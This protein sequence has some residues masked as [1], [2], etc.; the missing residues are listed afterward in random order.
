MTTLRALPVLCLLAGSSLVA[1]GNDVLDTTNASSSS[2]AGAGGG[3]S[4]SGSGAGTGGGWEAQFPAPHPGM[5]VIPTHGGATL[6]DPVIVT[7]TFPDDPLTDSAVSFGEQ[8]GGLNW[9]STVLADYG[10][11]PATSGGH[12]AMTDA[13]TATMTDNDLQTW[14]KGKI[15]DGTLP[16]PTDQHIYLLWVPASTTITLPD[17]QGPQSSCDAFLGYHSSTAMTINNVSVPIAYAVVNE[18]PPY[19]GQSALDG[20]T[21]TA[22][23]ELAEASSD[24]H[25]ISFTP[26]YVILGNTP[27][28]FAGGENADMCSEVSGVTEAGFYLT[29]VWSNANAK[30]G[31]QPCIPVPDDPTDTPYFNGGIVNETLKAKPGQTVSTEVD[32]YAFGPLANELTLQAMPFSHDVLTPSFDKATCINGEQ[33]KLSFKVSASAQPNDYHYELL[34]SLNADMAHAWRGMVTVE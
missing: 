13:L 8:I 1:C 9:W 21:D 32:C 5:P 16:P 22:S 4:G 12:V 17:P 20:A 26:G 29:R 18:C 19:P 30:I 10:V 28:T 34:V 27:W 24:P 11:G 2:A 3:S 6:H 31:Q 15:T 7:V 33:R 23:H 25:P 14:L